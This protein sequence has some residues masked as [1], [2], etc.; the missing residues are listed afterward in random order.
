MLNP[1]HLRTLTVVVE[2]G[3]FAA[4]AR[5][6]G[7]TSSAI[8]QQMEALEKATGLQLFERGVRGVRVTGMARV[9]TDRA[10]SVLTELTGLESEVKGLAKGKRGRVRIGCFA[11]AAARVLPTALSHLQVTHPDVDVSLRLTEPKYTM[12]MVESGE[13]DIGLTFGYP[14][15]KERWSDAIT[16]TPLLKE[17]LVF[18]SPLSAGI[19][20]VDDLSRARDLA[21]ISTGPGSAGELTTGRICAD[22]GFVPRLTLQTKYYDLVTEFV[23]AGLGVAIVPAL[24]LIDHSSVSVVP[25][26]SE[27]AYRTV[28]LIH[29]NQVSN[30]LIPIVAA[31]FAETVKT[32]AWGPFISAYGVGV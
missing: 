10:R 7:Y 21:W 8:S 25:L 29:L 28:A 6:L 1:L 32:R 15:L 2:S 13:L 12:P 26:E 18:L 9:L 17:K 23:G 22:L 19:H 24:G 3:S 4:A 27:W 30:P 20:H 11:S 16:V 31:S 5:E 14:V